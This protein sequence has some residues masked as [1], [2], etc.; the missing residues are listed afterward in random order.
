MRMRTGELVVTVEW[1]KK[2]QQQPQKNNRKRKRRRE[3]EIQEN[4]HCAAAGKEE[5]RDTVHWPFYTMWCCSVHECSAVQRL[6]VCLAGAAAFAALDPLSLCIVWVEQ[7]SLWIVN[8]STTT[9][10]HKKN[11]NNIVFI[12]ILTLCF[13]CI[14]SVTI[15]FC[16]L[17]ILLWRNSQWERRDRPILI[18]NHR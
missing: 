3:E 16:T 15:N 17:A 7:R 12:Y 13:P 2:Q 18:N 1:Q 8:S 9:T 4:V 5:K 10:D 11:N 14:K 6:Y